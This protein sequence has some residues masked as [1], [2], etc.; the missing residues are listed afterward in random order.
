MCLD[1]HWIHRNNYS[2]LWATSEML[3]I[4]PGSSKIAAS[5]FNAEHL[6]S[7]WPLLKIT[8]FNCVCVCYA[9][10]YM[11]MQLH[12]LLYVHIWRSEVDLRMVSSVTLHLTFLWQIL[13][14]TMSLSFSQTGWPM[15][16][17]DL[18]VCPLRDGVTAHATKTGFLYRDWRSKLEFS[19][20]WNHGTTSPDSV[21]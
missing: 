5:A 19:W 2:W 18:P 16:S 6:S 9:C 7:S 20:L 11:C 14:W 4:E 17:C 21:Q 10:V 8:L 15:S 3:G 12:S 1:G 13:S